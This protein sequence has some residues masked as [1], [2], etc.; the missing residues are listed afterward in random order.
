MLHCYTL[1]I[2]I[3]YCKTRYVF[4]YIYINIYTY[5]LVTCNNV[6]FAVYLWEYGINVVT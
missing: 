5:T 6:T 3:C 1:H 2:Y 4:L